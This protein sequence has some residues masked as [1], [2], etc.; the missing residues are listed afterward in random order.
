VDT[1]GL[2]HAISV[3]TADV[4]DRDGAVGMFTEFRS[5]LTRV[6]KVLVDG[7]YTGETFAN[8]IGDTLGAVVEVAKRSELHKF[9]VIPK[10]WIVERSFAWIDRCRRMWKNC[11]KYLKTT[12]Q[13]VALVFI[14]VI[15]KRF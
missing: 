7:G 14:R 8:A 9:V 1:I 4:T 3:T 13:F 6:L 12:A 2:P 10:R 5:N 15:L 11:E